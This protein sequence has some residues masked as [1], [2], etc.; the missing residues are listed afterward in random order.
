MKNMLAMLFALTSQQAL[1][2]Q[3]SDQAAGVVKDMRQVTMKNLPTYTAECWRNKIDYQDWKYEY[4]VC[5]RIG[6]SKDWEKDY[7]QQYDRKEWLKSIFLQSID[8]KSFDGSP[9][10]AQVLQAVAGQAA[11]LD[12]STAINKP[13]LIGLFDLLSLATVAHAEKNLAVKRVNAAVKTRWYILV[14]YAR[15]C[16]SHRDVCYPKY[17]EDFYAIAKEDWSPRNRITAMSLIYF[18]ETDRAKATKALEEMSGHDG[19]SAVSIKEDGTRYNYP[20]ASENNRLFAQDLLNSKPAAKRLSWACF[21][22]SLSWGGSR[23][24]LHG[25]AGDCK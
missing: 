6:Y 10:Q 4:P 2:A 25:A 15:L 22:E 3:M 11:S 20:N 13:Y 12:K 19:E 23:L 8:K 1:N 21:V 7:G 16:E 18:M 24:M 5:A 17:F 14:E 9:L